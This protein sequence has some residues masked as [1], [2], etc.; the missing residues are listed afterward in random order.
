MGAGVTSVDGGMVA[1]GEVG[2]FKAALATPILFQGIHDPVVASKAIEDGQGDLAMFARPALADPD[3]ARKVTERNQQAIVR[4]LR[5]NLC[6][7]RMVF[8]M[9]VRCEVNPAMGRESRVGSS[10]P[11][12]DRVFRAPVEKAIL[13]LTGSEAVMGVVGTL[14]GARKSS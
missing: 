6:M 7:R 14:M 2:A 3:F 12:L 9:P 5:D 11:P 13:G 4:C 10:L 8:G 1:S